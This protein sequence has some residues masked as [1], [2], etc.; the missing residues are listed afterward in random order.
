[1]KKELKC[2]YESNQ[3]ELNELSKKLNDKV[4][5]FKTLESKIDVEVS[6]ALTSQKM[7][8]TDTVVMLVSIVIDDGPTEYALTANVSN[9]SKEQIED[10]CWKLNDLLF[11]EKDDA[12]DLSWIERLEKTIPGLGQYAQNRI[13]FTVL[14]K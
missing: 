4:S 2:L 7:G 13:G 11:N 9:C 14:A 6:I 8:L 12:Y 3:E 5:K 10:F 1:M